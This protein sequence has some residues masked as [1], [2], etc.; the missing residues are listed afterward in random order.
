VSLLSKSR[1]QFLTDQK[2]LSKTCEYDVGPLLKMQ[3]T[4]SKRKDL[5][6]L[7]ENYL[8]DVLVLHCLDCTKAH[9][10]LVHK[11]TKKVVPDFDHT[12]S[13]LL[14]MN[15]YLFNKSEVPSND[16]QEIRTMECLYEQ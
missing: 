15:L 12:I 3:V 7:S 10:L 4:L 16:S 6:L 14:R 1:V 9:F 2:Q 13:I 5:L 11:M 8:M